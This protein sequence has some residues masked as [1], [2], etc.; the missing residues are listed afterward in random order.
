MI[1]DTIALA[2]AIVFG[3]PLVGFLIGLG[4][5]YATDMKPPRSVKEITYK[6]TYNN[7]DKK[8]ADR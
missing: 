4:M 8:N 2:I 3:L 5:S 7:L 1:T 6:K